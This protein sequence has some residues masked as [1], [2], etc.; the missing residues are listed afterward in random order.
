MQKLLAF[1][2][3]YAL[4]IG[5][6]SYRFVNGRFQ[7][8]RI[9]KTYV[10]IVNLGL[11]AALPYCMWEVSK[12]NSSISLYPRFVKTVPYVLDSINNAVILYA[13]VLRGRRDKILLEMDRLITQVNR[14]MSK[15]GKNTSSKLCKVLY[16][17]IC[18]VAS[19]S[20][21]NLMQ[22]FI[23]GLPVEFRFKPRISCLIVT[24]GKNL[25]VASTF[26]YFLVFWNIA[27]GYDFINERIDELIPQSKSKKKEISRLW[28]LHFKLGRTF[29]RINRLFGPQMLTARL[30]YFSYTVMNSYF[31]ILL[32]NEK[33]TP[34]F[35]MC[36]WSIVFLLHTM[37][38]FLSD[39]IIGLAT[40]TQSKR[41]DS[42]TEENGTM[43]KETSA[44]IIYETSM[45]LTERFV[46]SSKPI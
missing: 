34:N 14:E 32:W 3:E 6:T 11:L 15:S 28:D 26:Q 31:G 18:L 19:R 8:T 36:M 7:Q 27:R 9:T 16:L 10:W 21:H 17:K 38:S 30:N 45:K 35:F 22:C 42:I 41:R 2:H 12:F 1:F 24:I 44:Y 40:E 13:L 39:Y 37:S 29:T 25:V 43:S 5:L 46:D 4:V 23:Y 20:L 33:S